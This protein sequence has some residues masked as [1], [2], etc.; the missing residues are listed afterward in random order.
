M[1]DDW[2]EKPEPEELGK[3]WI[4]AFRPPGTDEAEI[5]FFYNG[6]R[7][8]D[9]TRGAFRSTLERGSA[10]RATDSRCRPSLSA[11]RE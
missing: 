10:I 6:L 7:L 5:G 3:A 2:R 11:E 1:P 9:T 8:S 4:R